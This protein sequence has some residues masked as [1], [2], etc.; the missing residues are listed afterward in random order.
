M[1]ERK[2]ERKEGEERGKEGGERGKVSFFPTI[3]CDVVMTL[4]PPELHRNV[5]AMK[6]V[7]PKDK[8][9]LRGQDGMDPT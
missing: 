8:R 5:V 2:K 9:V 1:E 6:E 7:T 4:Y 3:I